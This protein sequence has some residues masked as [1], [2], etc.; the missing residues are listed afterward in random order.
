[1]RR[2]TVRRLLGRSPAPRPPQALPLHGYVESRTIVPHV[3]TLADDELMELNRLLPWRSYTVDSRGRR[4][5]DGTPSQG[6]GEDEKRPAIPDPRVVAMHEHFDLRDK[7]VLEV[8]CYEGGHTIGLCQL[9]AR[10]T[11]VD[12]RVANVVKTIVRCAFYGHHPRA[13]VCNLDTW[14]DDDALRAD[15]VYHVGVLYH[16]R[17]PVEHL[18]RLRDIARVGV[19]LDTQV[20]EDDEATEWMTVNGREY[21]YK[22]HGEDPASSPKAGMFDHAKWLRVDDIVAL[23]E[24]CGFAPAKV[25]GRRPER[26][27]TRATIMAGPQGG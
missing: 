16:L 2:N 27:G 15:V 19:L 22:H 10:V 23:L 26:N 9:A 11:A 4:F 7:H 6:E 14:E 17:D 5:G 20:A 8:G 3:E 21:R 24:E 1:M 12:A 18:L 25:V 13:F